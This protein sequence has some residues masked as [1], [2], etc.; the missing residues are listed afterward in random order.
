MDHLNTNKK[1]LLLA[2]YFCCCLIGRGQSAFDTQAS[3]SI[4]ETMKHAMQVRHQLAT[5]ITSSIDS[6]SK[7]HSSFV[8]DDRDPVRTSAARS[9]MDDCAELYDATLDHL[10]LSLASTS[11]SD[12][13][14]WL[15]AAVANRETCHDGFLD[16]NVSTSSPLLPRVMSQFSESLTNALAVNSRAAEGRKL[17]TAA[18]EEEFPSWVAD[19][20]RKLLEMSGGG[21]GRPAA[22]IVVAQDGTGDYRTISE[23]VAAMAK[24]RKNAAAEGKR[25]VIYVKKGVYKESVEIKKSMKNVMMIGDGIDVTVVTNSK[26]VGG[27]FTTYRSA[28]FAVSG[29]G[30]IAK[31]MT[32]ENT[33]GPQNHQA[34]AFRSSSD[35]SVFFRCSFKGYQDT[36]YV[37]S[38]RQFYRDCDIYGTIDFIFGDAAV[39]LQSC[40]IYVRRPMSRQ[41]NTVTAQGRSD[42]NEN[43]AIV[44]QGS[45]IMAAADL[46]QVQGSFE[47]YLGR[48][49]KQ[50]SRTLVMKSNLGGLINPAGWLPWNGEFALRTLYYGEYMNSGIGGR[51]ERRVSWP[52]F[53][54]IRSPTVAGKFSVGNFL[55]GNA[56]IPSSGVPYDSGL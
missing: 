19:G 3:S 46:A 31:D 6:N 16:L 55:H 20:D 14:T 38:Q 52:G 8:E 25:F 17:M 24:M 45:R 37:H 4:E 41:K 7:I 18:E 50:Y 33:A 1:K 11:A 30:F 34:V 22:H 48:P 26:S 56:W 51:T 32:F 12:T 42:P 13:L 49:W 28:T 54:V 5:M 27:G 35:L 23:A 21:G 40:N 36:L 44:I 10:N 53:H 29:A 15:S 39:V 43:T 47:T 2:Y 9:A